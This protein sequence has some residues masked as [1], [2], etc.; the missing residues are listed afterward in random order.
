MYKRLTID[1]YIIDCYIVKTMAKIQKKI[2][3]NYTTK[4]PV[5]IFN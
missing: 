4:N 1:Y 3:F 2:V 5:N